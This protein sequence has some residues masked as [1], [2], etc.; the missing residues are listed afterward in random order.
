MGG[1]WTPP[2]G[3]TGLQ[4]ASLFSPARETDTPALFLV[5][6]RALYL[7]LSLSRPCLVRPKSTK[8]GGS[9]ELPRID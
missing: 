4:P 2:L 5:S 3:S 9:E 6:L 7:Y 1:R 8:E